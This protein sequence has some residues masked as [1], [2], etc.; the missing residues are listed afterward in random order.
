MDRG[1]WRAAEQTAAHG[2]AK[3]QTRLGDGACMQDAFAL[4]VLFNLLGF[5]PRERKEHSLTVYFFYSQFYF[6]SLLLA[7]PPVFNS[8]GL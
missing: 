6:F 2:V 1:D 5:Q 3:S 7:H 4:I 8:L